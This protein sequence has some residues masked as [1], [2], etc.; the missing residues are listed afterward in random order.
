M[1]PRALLVAV[2][3]VLLASARAVEEEGSLLDVLNSYIKDALT[4]VE[5]HVALPPSSWMTDGFS[6]LKESWSKL[7][8]FWN[9]DPETTP[10]VA[11]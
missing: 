10:T 5:S 8:R 1:Q 7:S 2:L 6:S 4:S 9:P 3:L 11:P